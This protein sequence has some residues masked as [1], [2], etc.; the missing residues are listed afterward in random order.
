MTRHTIGL[1]VTLALGL[2]AVPLTAQAQ[3]STKVPRIGY[4]AVG[5]LAS[6][7]RLLEAFKQGLR[8]LGWIEGQTIAIEY[9][10]V[11]GQMDRLPALAAELVR[12]PVD[13]IVTTSTPVSQAAKDATSSIPIVM[14][15]SADPVGTGLVA[16]LARPGGNLTGMSALNP[17]LGGKRFELL[18]ELLPTLSRAAFLLHGGIPPIDSSSRKR[19][20]RPRAS[21]S[22]CSRW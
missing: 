9:R 8:D 18:Q 3:S 19:R 1:I 13:L 6:H 10:W 4:L 15:V 2:L 20:P 21:A 17:E 14:A 5:T 16:N 11:T 12:L 22:S 7:G